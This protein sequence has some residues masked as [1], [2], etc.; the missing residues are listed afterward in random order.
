M[1]CDWGCAYRGAYRGCIANFATG[2][3]IVLKPSMY[4]V[5]AVVQR[6]KHAPSR[7]I[8]HMC[9]LIILL[10]M[11]VGFTICALKY[12]SPSCK[13]QNPITTSEKLLEKYYCV[14]NVFVC[15]CVSSALGEWCMAF[16]SQTM[17]LVSCLLNPVLFIYNIE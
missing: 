7:S 9:I 4:L 2:C 8:F 17:I 14:G 15:V 6:S 1:N 13:S 16:P 11:H 12:I 10:C 3:K 5:T